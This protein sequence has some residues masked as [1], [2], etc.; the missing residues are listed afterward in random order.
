MKALIIYDNFALAAKANGLLQQAA[1]QADGRLHWNIRPWRVDVLRWPPG[2]DEA[3]VDAA[4]AHLIV[5]AGP[6]AQSLPPWL[7]DWLERW[8][9]RRQIP[10]AALSAVG[11]IR[12]DSLS[13]SASP[14][15]F[16]FAI[17]HGLNFVA[18]DHLPNDGQSAFP[19]RSIPVRG[20]FPASVKPPI[21]N[22]VTHDEPYRRWGINE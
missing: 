21:I 6:R 19:V 13:M 3:L 15:L 1:Q 20:I 22:D 11:G 14:E 12:D 17:E 9:T 2:A 18:D 10:D 7:K 4:D 5:L 8:D 16:R